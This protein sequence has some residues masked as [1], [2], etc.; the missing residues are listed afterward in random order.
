MADELTGDGVTGKLYP[1][2]T[3]MRKEEEILAAFA[4]ADSELGGADVLVNNAG[5]YF[6]D[7]LVGKYQTHH[8]NQ[9]IK[10]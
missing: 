1:Q 10:E 6:S 8:S 5:L 2:K 4:R 7:S 9:I 3:D